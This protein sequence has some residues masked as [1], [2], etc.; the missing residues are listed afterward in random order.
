MRY[1]NWK[2]RQKLDVLRYC[3]SMHCIQ[4]TIHS[5]GLFEDLRNSEFQMHITIS[6]VIVQAIDN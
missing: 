4:M 1:N 5:N 3:N 2:R 6:P